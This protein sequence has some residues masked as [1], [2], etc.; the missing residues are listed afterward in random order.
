MQPTN[1]QIEKLLNIKISRNII[2]STKS[3]GNDR[4]RVN[5]Y[6]KYYTE[7]SIVPRTRMLTSRYL[8]NQNGLRDITL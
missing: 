8:C 2:Y 7:G 4:Y 6:E 5:V 1:E 3:V